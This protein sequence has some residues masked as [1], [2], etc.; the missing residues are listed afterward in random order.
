MKKYI[1]ILFLALAA[2]AGRPA[3]HLP[4]PPEPTKQVLVCDRE[5]SRTPLDIDKTRT[6]LPLE[7][8]NAVLRT[9]LAQLKTYVIELEASFT[10]CG[11]KVK[12]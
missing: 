6:G 2:C 1:V 4:T 7:Q 12:K 5:V 9:S 3:A 10:Q 8:Q 11:G